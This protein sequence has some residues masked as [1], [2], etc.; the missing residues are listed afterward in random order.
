MGQREIALEVPDGLTVEGL[1]RRLL[2]EYPGLARLSAL[3]RLSVNREY[4]AG[5]QILEDG[6]EVA[7]IPPV[8]GGLDRYEVTEERLSLDALA[9]AMRQTT[10]GAIASFVGVVRE[11]SRGR[12]VLY[13]E[14]DAYPE[15]ALAAMRAIGEEIRGRWPIDQV[16][17]VHR[18]GRLQIGETSVAI[19]VSSPH[20]R[21]ALQACAHAIERVKEI[22]PIW[23]KEVWTDGQ[24]WIGSTVD[25]YQ[26]RQ[27]A[28]TQPAPDAPPEGGR[29]G[30]PLP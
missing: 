15:M 29:P 6:D 21:E 12:Q 22:V 23:K 13:L 1:L 24:E 11:F 14:Y 25:E 17:I 3:S 10:S 2:A 7:L 8:S 30:R 4:V 20:R 27:A 5:G 16:A 18:I 9:S 26:Q 19:V 28:P